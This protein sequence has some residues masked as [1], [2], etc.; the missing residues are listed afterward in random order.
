MVQNSYLCISINQN[1]TVTSLKRLAILGST[2][3][4]GTQTLEVISE[5]PQLF[6]AQ[7]LV[8]GRNADLL[9][10]QCQHYHPVLAV[11]ADETAYQKVKDA[12][13][14]L[15]IIVACGS[16]AIVEA[17][18][19]DDVDEVLTAT[20]GY[21]GLAPTIAAIKAGKDIALA[22]KETLV[23]AGELVMRLLRESKSRLLPVDSEHSAIYQCLVGEAHESVEKLILTASG[24]PFRTFTAE[25]LCHVTVN[26]AL[27]HPNWSMGAK[28]TIDSATMLNKAFEIIEA[29]WLFDIPGD[30]IEAV[31]HPQSIVHSMVEFVDGSVK[32]QLGMP[33]MRMPIRYALGDGTR[34]H[35]DVHRLK[36]S[37]CANLTFE[38]PDE[39]RFPCLSLGRMALSNGGTT[40]CTIN[41]ANEIAVAAFLQGKIKF[42]E[43]YETIMHTLGKVEFVEN[44]CY[45]DYVNINA[46]A[47]RCASEFISHK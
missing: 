31:V 23:V 19:R 32:A 47:R 11:I 4:I 33:D 22:N 26:D 37:D 29:R 14:P 8:A 6:K 5:Y 20:V 39:K 28:I 40:A 36:V 3:S 21:S 44:P 10:K 27:K 24:G 25:Q 43:I 45:E 42:L 38:C 2:G 17:V 16:D 13:Q 34:L 12:L 1:I 35:T 41:A 18:T 46:I 15:G 9:I 30:K 7:V